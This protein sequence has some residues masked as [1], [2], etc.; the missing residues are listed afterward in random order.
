[1][2]VK[3][4]SKMSV[5][6]FTLI[7]LLVVI[8]IIAL[9]ISILLPS[10]SRARELSKRLVC[11]SN[12]KGIGLT[13]KIYAN[14]NTDK[15]PTPA[16][17]QSALDAGRFINYLAPTN[18]NTDPRNP[19]NVGYNRQFQG[20]SD[21]KGTSGSTQVTTT[22]AFWLVIRSGE[23]TV[24]QFICPSSTKDPD[25]TEEI[26][27]YYDFARY[28]NVSYGYLVPFGPLDTRPSESRDA[29]LG[30]AA[31]GTPFY[32]QPPGNFTWIP[33]GTNKPV[34]PTNPPRDWRQYNSPNH[35]GLGVGEGQNVLIADGHVTFEKTPIVGID[36]DNIYTCM[37]RNATDFGRWHGLHPFQHPTAAFPMGPYPGLETFGVGRRGGRSTTDT[38]IYP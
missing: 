5:K 1:M 21:W 8:A 15:W 28:D 35:G 38:L 11:G 14:D 7:E 20:H 36:R 9:L 18:G 6:G 2:S 32:S 34:E 29:R 4:W 31:D 37:D 13:C 19:V 25:D 27:F 23:T 17:S 3:K 30:M 10:L 33:P 16:F 12:L 26:D 22:R 24:K